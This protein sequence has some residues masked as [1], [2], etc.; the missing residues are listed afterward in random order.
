[1]NRKEF[2]SPNLIFNTASDSISSKRITTTIY[3]IF[4]AVL[5]V[6]LKFFSISMPNTENYRLRSEWDCISK[7]CVNVMYKYNN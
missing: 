1:M 4:W 2:L 7:I 5:C 3:G 6:S